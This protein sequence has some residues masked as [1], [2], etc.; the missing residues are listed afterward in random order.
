MFNEKMKIEELSL[1]KKYH[2]N[3]LRKQ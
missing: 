1:N 2:A 3:F